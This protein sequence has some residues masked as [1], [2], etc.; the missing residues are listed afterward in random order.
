M[1]LIGSQKSK[2]NT[3][4]KS[5]QKQKTTTRKQDAKQKEI[6]HDDSK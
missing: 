2:K 6:K 1:F 4:Y 3:E 5:Q